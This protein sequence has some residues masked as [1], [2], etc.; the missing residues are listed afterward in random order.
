MECTEGF[1]N[2]DRIVFRTYG[3]ARGSFVLPE[4]VGEI[5]SVLFIDSDIPDGLLC[6]EAPV[7]LA[8]LKMYSMNGAPKT[9]GEVKWMLQAG[10]YKFHR[11]V[12]YRFKGK[13]FLFPAVP[14]DGRVALD[15]YVK[16]DG[17]G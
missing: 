16:S 15:Y 13:L 4:D 6:F 3:E 5:E 2:R 14:C 8:W 12:W 10:H 17:A 7:T 1:A 11:P 9:E